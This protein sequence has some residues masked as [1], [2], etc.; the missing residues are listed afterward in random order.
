[1]RLPIRDIHS[2][3]LPGV[4]DGFSS[5]TDSLE[6]L[7]RMKVQGVETVFL[8]P[9]INPDVTPRISESFLR[10]RYSAFVD[11]IGANPAPGLELAAE[12]MVVKD[13]E[14]RASDPDLL[15]F[16]DG[17]V[18]IEMSYYFPSPN[19]EQTL[20]EMTMA[21]RKPIL[22]HPERYLYLSGSLD[23][24]DRYI[25]MG[26]R[27]QGNLLSLSGTYGPESL[28]I[29]Q[30]LLKKNYYSFFSTDLHTVLQLE[31]ILSSSVHRKLRRDTSNFFF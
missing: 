7:R 9:H 3:I 17:S 16:P 11:A 29:A 14:K 21:G 15:A 18:L 13:F 5:I 6:A 23:E 4:D 31:L 22:A 2:H 25:D 27:F 20:F 26:C 19:L 10:D 1:M 8:T 30:Y 24:F 12:Y 28:R